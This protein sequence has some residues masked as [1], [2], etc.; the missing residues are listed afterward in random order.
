G[1]V[2]GGLDRALGHETVSG[3]WRRGGAG[4]TDIGVVST[5]RV[6]TQCV[7]FFR[8]WEVILLDGNCRSFERRGM[9][10]CFHFS[11]HGSYFGLFSRWRVSTRRRLPRRP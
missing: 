8:D 5:R 1:R 6:P 11:T 9:P 10:L 3:D 4:W 7:R 2:V